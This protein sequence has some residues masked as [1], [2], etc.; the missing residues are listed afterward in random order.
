V[1]DLRAFSGETDLYINLKLRL[2]NTSRKPE[3]MN[4][5]W[6]LTR[7]KPDKIMVAGTE[8]RIGS[9]VRLNPKGKAE[10]FDVVLK[11]KTATIASLE[12]D[13]E[14]RVFVTVTVSEEFTKDM[15]QFGHRFFFQT[16]EVEPI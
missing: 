12:E 2:Q 4:E 13:F 8:L 6:N 14:G 7:G 1:L 10:V 5:F 3:D 11:G 9:P 15:G 16:D